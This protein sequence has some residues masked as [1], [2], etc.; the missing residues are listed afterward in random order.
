MNVVISFSLLCVLLV[1]GKVLRVKVK[2]LRKLYLPSSVIGG[3]VGLTIIQI[4]GASLPESCIAGWKELQ[5]FLLILSL[6]H[7]FL[8]S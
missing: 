4:V 5:D 6:P 1:I 8:A 7:F 2:I 3:L